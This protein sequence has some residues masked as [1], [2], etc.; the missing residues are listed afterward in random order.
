M[1]GVTRQAYVKIFAGDIHAIQITLITNIDEQGNNMDAYILDNVLRE[2]TSR[3]SNDR[4]GHGSSLHCVL[5]DKK[6]RM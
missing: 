3:V 2:V 5:R 6:F 4:N 1:R